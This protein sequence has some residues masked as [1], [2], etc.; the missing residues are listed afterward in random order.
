MCSLLLSLHSFVNLI[1]WIFFTAFFMLRFDPI[2]LTDWNPNP[3]L[4]LLTCKWTN[5]E[6]VKVSEKCFQC[7]HFFFCF[8]W[9]LTSGGLSSDRHGCQNLNLDRRIARSY[10]TKTFRIALG[11]KNGRRV[12][13]IPYYPTNP[14]KNKKFWFFIFY[15]INFFVLMKF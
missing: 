8:E 9:V 2:E 14:T 15:G 1:N 13:R 10:L 7:P 5:K 11:C 6:I 12:R 3:S 4:Q